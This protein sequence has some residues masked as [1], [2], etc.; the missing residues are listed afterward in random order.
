MATT[1]PSSPMD[2]QAAE[3]LTR[4]MET[5]TILILK[6]LSL[7]Q[8]KSTQNINSELLIASISSNT[9]PISSLK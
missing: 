3:K 9:Y 2:R 1:G 5:F 6:A 4:C 8:G 7:E